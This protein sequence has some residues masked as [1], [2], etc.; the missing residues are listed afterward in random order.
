MAKT[1]QAGKWVLGG[2]V[3]AAGVVAAVVVVA[4]RDRQSSADAER[5][6]LTS[7]APA[8][9]QPETGPRIVVEPAPEV[10]ADLS[11]PVFDVVRVGQ[12]GGA[13]VAGAAR[14]GWAVTLRVDGQSVAEAAADTAGQFVAMFTLAPSDMPQTLTLE[15]A[16]AA[17]EVIAA[18]ET[19][20][21][22][23][24]PPVAVAIAAPAP[25]VEQPVA[26]A[27]QPQGADQPVTAEAENSSVE[28]VAEQPA[29]VVPAPEQ[30]GVEPAAPEVVAAV[31]PA[32]QATQPAPIEPVP[33]AQAPTESAPAE[34]APVELA[35]AQPTVEAPAAF[36]VRESGRVDLLA[37]PPV[38][39]VVIDSI[40]YS[41][42]GDVL[43]SGRTSRGHEADEIRLYLDNAFLGATQANRGAW[44][45]RLS[46]IVPGVYTLRVD[47]VD[48]TGRVTS[49]FETPFLREAPEVVRAAQAQAQPEQPAPEATDA[50]AEP[51]SPPQPPVVASAPEPVAPEPVAPEP[52]AAEPVALAS[53]APEPPAPVVSP[54]EPVE[55]APTAPEPQPE[56]VALAPQPQ[57]PAQESPPV[58]EAVVETVASAP[59]P[60]VQVAVTAAE[61][62][63]EPAA[64]SL[65]EPTP[66]APVTP[67]PVT[68]A[69]AVAVA[70][71]TVITVQP[72]HTLWGISAQHYGEGDLYVQIYNANRSQI[73]DPDLIYPGQIFTLP[74][75]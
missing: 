55:T 34:P 10:Q 29:P 62:A 25:V 63:V 46:G 67:A 54:A 6:S 49:R 57:A 66:P 69:P 16:N 74:T 24:R 5:P 14:P 11:V 30:Q 35:A 32:P 7:L 2:S 52:V 9:P 1:S 41:A 15:M 64:Q 42:E 23:P 70:R 33:A 39:N 38:Q 53:A 20:I 65:A 45:A 75:N 40:S 59:A 44:V 71:A 73:R 8:T 26:A 61:P 27:P 43:L 3:L 47:Q 12:D 56:P 4:T 58:A 31:D 19:V 17:G 13:L 22:T 51:V 36:V 18:R 48:D 72:G 50:P 28:S 68:P 21:L 37:A 60:E